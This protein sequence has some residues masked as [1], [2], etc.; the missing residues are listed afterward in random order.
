MSD[1]PSDQVPDSVSTEALFAA[2]GRGF[3][4]PTA[5]QTFHFGDTSR[6]EGLDDL[7]VLLTLIFSQKD[8]RP[9]PSVVQT[10]G[11]IAYIS[12]LLSRK[13]REATSASLQ[14]LEQDFER[15]G[16]S[17]PGRVREARMVLAALNEDARLTF[18]TLDKLR[19]AA[20]ELQGKARQGATI[21]EMVQTRGKSPDLYRR[22]RFV[23]D[24]FLDSVGID[25]KAFDSYL[26]NR[27]GS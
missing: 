14:A 16:N 8:P 11:A 18:A 27:T 12:D 2:L 17:D 3:P 21:V 1:T 13:I 15:V 26:K 23:S 24:Q 5:L 10:I 25:R 9:G 6:H 4:D 7:V 20:F 19:S 22:Q